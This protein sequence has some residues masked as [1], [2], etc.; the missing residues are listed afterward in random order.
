MY[1]LKLMY[2][3]LCTPKIF[4]SPYILVCISIYIY[5]FM[6]TAMYKL[7]FIFRVHSGIFHLFQ[8]VHSGIFVSFLFAW[9][10]NFMDQCIIKH[11]RC[12]IWMQVAENSKRLRSIFPYIK[13]FY[14]TAMYTLWTKINPI[15]LV[16]RGRSRHYQD[17]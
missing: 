1:G 2:I 11:K 12:L 4:F 7:K 6:G 10:N 5:I 17:R 8:Y 9:S 16:F 14:S 3:P 13:I 15:F